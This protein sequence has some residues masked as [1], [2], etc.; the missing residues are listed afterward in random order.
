VAAAWDA[1]QRGLKVALLEAEDF[2]AGVSWN[3]L[4]TIHG[5]LRHLQR[6]DLSGLREST[7]EQRALLN[8]APALVKPLAFLVPSYGH[9]L[10]GREALA[11]G[12]WLGDLL[13]GGRNRGLAPEQ[14]LPPSRFLS[15]G[16]VRELVPGLSTD[17]LTGGALYTD[18]QV[19][20]SERLTLA[21]VHAAADAGAIA[22]NHVMATEFL[23]EK[24]RI[25]G[26]RARDVLGGT[27]FDVR[28][29][30]VLNATGPGVDDLL[31]RAGIA[32]P[33]APLL[34]AL[35]LVLG[36]SPGPKDLALGAPSGGRFLFLVPWGERALLGTAYQP[37]EEPEAGF[38]DKFLGEAAQAYPWAGLT[39]EDVVLVH[40]GLVP[41]RGGA[42]G[43]LNRPRLLDHEATDGLPGLLSVQ[44]VKYT[45]ARGVAEAAV[46]RVFG[47]LG[48]PGPPCRTAT[49]PLARARPLE[50]TLAERAAQ[51]VHEEMALT[52][53][54]AV[55]RR[56]DLGTGGPPSAA[57]LETVTRTMAAA[58]GWGRARAQ[59]EEAALAKNYARA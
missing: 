49:T 42:G 9:G 2:G 30:L 28:A 39:P 43:L 32:R 59:A 35:N 22:A 53:A 23:R 10:R 1:A 31:R 20:S 57:E 25:A 4:K 27:D 34:R 11:V 33:A 17:G 47:R 38:A 21:F 29:R 51:A 50:G 7:R 48:R 56:L 55:L 5:G 36:R 16:A 54:D 13:G 58:L 3:S 12:L 40:R 15:P 41:G 19:T 8:I 46:D 44:G 18:A 14:S 52:L 24:T 6:A 26:V 45:T 37:A